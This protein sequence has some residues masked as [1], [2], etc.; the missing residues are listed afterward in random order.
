MLATSTYYQILIAIRQRIADLGLTD[1]PVTQLYLRRVP[2]DRS[3]DLPAVIISP[4]GT[5]TLLIGTNA[6]ED[7]G[8]PVLVTTV[9][10][11]TKLPTALASEENTRDLT[12]EVQE[13][14]LTWRETIRFAFHNQRLPGVALVYRCLVEPQ[15]VL[16]L[17]LFRDQ[18]LVVSGLVVRCHTREQR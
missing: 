1:I 15:P 16:D 2:T 13:L 18:G 3:V 4:L 12:L 8:Y 10:G 7:T 11:V 14:E 9:Q 17:P 6:S 5:E